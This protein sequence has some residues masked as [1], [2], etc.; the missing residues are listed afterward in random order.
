MVVT[1]SGPLMALG[2]LGHLDLLGRLY[3]Q[4][5]MPSAV[6]NEVV[7]KGLTRGCLDSYQ[8][9]LAIH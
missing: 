3:E 7:V 5:A 8:V 1:N 9:Q 2:K 4:V 6:H